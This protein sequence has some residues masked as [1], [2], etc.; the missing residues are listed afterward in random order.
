MLPFHET[1]LVYDVYGIL[2]RVHWRKTIQF[3]KFTLTVPRFRFPAQPLCPVSATLHNFC[4]TPSAVPTYQALCF[5]MGSFLTS[6]FM[7]RSFMATLKETLPLLDL[8]PK[9]YGTLFSSRGASFV[10][11]TDVVWC[12]V[13]IFTCAC[14]S[15]NFSPAAN[16]VMLIILFHL[17]PV[18]HY[19]NLLGFGHSSADFSLFFQ[20]NFA[21][22]SYTVF[23]CSA[24][25]HVLHLPFPYCNTKFDASYLHTTLC[26]FALLP[27]DLFVWW[28]TIGQ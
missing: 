11:V 28:A 2:Q 22:F 23:I 7:Y 14:I 24:H 19:T 3:W 20:F 1:D 5:Q 18:P 27:I 21:W 17:F 8:S 12:C 10:L 13:S 16:S 15:A 6:C 4:L 9:D 26:I 25:L